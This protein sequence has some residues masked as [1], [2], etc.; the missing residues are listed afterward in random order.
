MNRTIVW[1]RRDLRISDHPPLER[2]ARR[3]AVIPLFI[4]D[5]ALLHHPE[6]GVGRVAFLLNCLRSLDQDL[7][8]RG[9]RL[10]LRYGNPLDILPQFVQETEAEGIYAHIDFERIYGRVRDGKLNAIAQRDSTFRIRWFEP[11]GFTSQLIP[12]SHYRRLWFE[13]MAAMVIPSPV[14]CIVPNGIPSE[15]I[16]NLE[17]LRLIPDTKPIPPG[18]TAAAHQRLEEFWVEKKERY[19]WQLSYPSANVT[20]GLSPYLKFGVISVRECVQ[21]LQRVKTIVDPRV[22]RSQQ[23]LVARLRWG[24]GFTQRFRYLPQLEL[25]SLYSIFDQQGW[26]FDEHLYQSWQAGQT[27]Y[28]II[29]AAARCLMATGGWQELNFRVRAIYASFLGNLLGIDWR[30]G[31]LHFMR[32]LIDGDCPIDHY[33]WAMQTGV[34]HCVDKSWTRIYNPGQVAV[35]RCDPEGEFIKRWVPELRGIHPSRLGNP[36]PMTNY[37]PAILNYNV[38]RKQCVQKLE[39]Q[40]S[41]FRHQPN[42]IPYLAALPED[43]TPFGSHRLPCDVN[44][45]HTASPADL[46]PPPI[47]LDQLDGEGAIALRTWF[48]AHLDIQPSR[49]KRKVSEPSTPYTQLE[50]L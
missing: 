4:L 50:L 35:D 49:T 40:R 3:G 9:G 43:L 28:P 1:F 45:S 12:Y 5:P 30:Y 17:D 29:D 14:R 47:N 11:V 37:P 16:P 39:R 33:Q 27:G 41:E 42:L 44:W 46:F 23:Q 19:Y 22:H 48:V 24:N 31:A 20:T 7:R 15:P 18:G 10:I 2:A 13:Q 36:P 8:Q 25:R 21:F 26:G 6:T 38:A 34:T 32:H